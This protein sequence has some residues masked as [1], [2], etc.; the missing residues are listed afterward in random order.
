MT[1]SRHTPQHGKTWL[2]TGVITAS[3]GLGL[4]GTQSVAA[5]ADTATD[6]DAS[7][8]ATPEVTPQSQ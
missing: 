7:R 3:L 2:Y 8:I 6:T 1:N 5:H 4:L